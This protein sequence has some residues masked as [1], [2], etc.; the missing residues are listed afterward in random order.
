ME[1]FVLRETLSLASSFMTR[2]PF[3]LKL[4]M[5]FRL[6]EREARFE[7]LCVCQQR[8]GSNVV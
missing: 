6:V 8:E 5:T 3:F 1:M 7:L 4:V 2:L